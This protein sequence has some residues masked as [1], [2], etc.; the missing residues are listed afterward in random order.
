MFSRYQDDRRNRLFAVA[1]TRAIAAAQK[2]FNKGDG[3][4]DG[5]AMR[6]AFQVGGHYFIAV[7]IF[8]PMKPGAFVLNLMTVKES[9]SGRPD[10]FPQKSG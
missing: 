3:L 2:R 10:V 8:T 5:M 4:P 7:L 9:F 6:R 1:K